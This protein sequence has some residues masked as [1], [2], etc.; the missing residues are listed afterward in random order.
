MPVSVCLSLQKNIK[1]AVQFKPERGG[2]SNMF[3]EPK[4]GKERNPANA[5]GKKEL[6]GEHHP[7]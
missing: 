1:A 4:Q 2:I 6:W 7:C 3:C 5:C